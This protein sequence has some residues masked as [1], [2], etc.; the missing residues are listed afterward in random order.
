MDIKAQLDAYFN[1]QVFGTLAQ[2]LL[3]NDMNVN[4][5]RPWIEDE[6]GSPYLG[7][8]F[9]TN[10]KDKAQPVTNATLRKDEW[11]FYDTAVQLAARQRLVGIADL[12]SRGLVLNLGNGMSKTVLEYED[13]KDFLTAH[14]S[15][16]GLTPGKADRPTYDIKYLPLPIIHADWD[17]NSRVLA[18]SRN[19]NTPLDTTIAE[20][21]ARVVA[22]QLEDLLFT[23]TTYTFGAGTIRS[24]VNASNRNTGSLSAHWNDSAATGQTILDDVL[25]MKQESIDA[26]HFGPWMLYIPTT[27]ETALDDN[28]TTNYPISVRDRIKQ[29][30]GIIDIKIADRLATDTVLLV[31]M[32]TDTVRLVKGLDI[33]PVEWQTEGGLALHYKIMTIQVPQVRSDQSGKS[34]IVHY[35]GA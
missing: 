23:D 28:F 20:M 19:G 5:M 17:I 16:D 6:V 8:A 27:Y 33:M 34:G 15:M 21:A 13:I 10:A 26:Y 7:R 30:A 18:S 12:E 35:T 14:L 25:A 24:Y 4:L 11:K 9:V 32:A 29:I 22:V 2:R 3:Q 31:Q 1:G